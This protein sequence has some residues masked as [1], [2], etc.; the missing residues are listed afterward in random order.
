MVMPLTGQCTGTVIAGKYILTAAHCLKEWGDVDTV[1]TVDDKH[2]A[3]DYAQFN[4]HPEYQPDGEHE[5]WVPDVGLIP[6][7]AALDYQHVQF[8]AN[9]SVELVKGQPVY[10]A[11]FGGTANEPKPL[12]VAEFYPTKKQSGITK[13]SMTNG[14]TGKLI[15]IR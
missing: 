13:G 5:G 12:N 6:L 14:T 3:A 11:G 15:L 9:P 8:L 2:V 10:V 1:T 4:L 7:D